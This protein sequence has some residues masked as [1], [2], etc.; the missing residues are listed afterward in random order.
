MIKKLKGVHVPHRKNTANKSAVKMNAPKSVTIPTVMHIGKPAL[1]IVKV[2]SSVKVGT[3]IALQNGFVSSCVHSSVS[4]TVTAIKD[5]LLSNGNTAPAIT[6]ESDGLMELDENIAPP[7]VDSKE[8]LIEAIKASG[9]VGLGGAGFPTY[10]KF[11]T[12]KEI[13]FLIINGAECEPYITSDS[14]TMLDRVDDI[15]TAIE[16]L[17]KYLNI[18]NVVIGIEKIKLLLLNQLPIWHQSLKTLV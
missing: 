6:I 3:V 11:A 9:I 18:K 13:E 14:V 5:I 17:C 16:T 12:D 7:K 4:G 8:S 10:V 15:S 2:G 1:P